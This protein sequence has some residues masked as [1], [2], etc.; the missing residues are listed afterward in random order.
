[1]DP[2]SAI[3][4]A[5]SSSS[6]DGE[7]ADIGQIDTNSTDASAAAAGNININV[8]T[9]NTANPPPN[10]SP[11]SVPQMFVRVNSPNNGVR[12]V[13]PTPVTMIPPRARVILRQAA[14]AN[15]QQQQ[16]QGGE[17]TAAAAATNQLH[18]QA[19]HIR[20]TS[21]SVP[22]YQP[23]EARPLPNQINYDDA[24]PSSNQNDTKPVDVKQF[25]CSICFE[26]M[27]TPVRCGSSA[28]SSRFCAP[29]L[30]R[31]LREEISNRAHRTAN[32][33]DNNNDETN[34]DQSAKCPTCRTSFTKDDIQVDLV[35]QKQIDDSTN[36]IT[37][38]FKGCN[39][40]VPLGQLKQHEQSCPYIR[41]K[42]K[43]AEWGCKWTGRKMDLQSHYD[44][45]CVY[46]SSGPGLP[47]FIERYRKTVEHDHRRWI[48]QHRVQ[49]QGV[50][51]MQSIQ[52]RQVMMMKSRNPADIVDIIALSYHACCYPGRFVMSRDLWSSILM[53]QGCRAT[54]GNMM[55]SFP[56]MVLVASVSRLCGEKGETISD[57]VDP[58]L[59]LTLTI[60]LVSSLNTGF[61]SRLVSSSTPGSI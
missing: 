23:L 50:N 26:Y 57:F 1:M 33:N 19:I 58:S 45:E 47:K 3:D 6:P 36:T 25:E 39:T 16:Q 14:P 20:Q 49:L 48:D 4:P 61:N 40:E 42:C 46:C 8:T 5:P 2:S 38:P 29:C 41:M 55:L 37:C 28:C 32:N 11:R 44:H 43:Y 54:M 34:N 15:I 31:V 22:V 18:P 53:K 60:F 52:S 17:S 30:T 27:D 24:M 13:M 56:T 12:A 10:P 21:S 35:L 59:L 7:V 9:T 51:Q